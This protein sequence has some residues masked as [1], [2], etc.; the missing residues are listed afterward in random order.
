MSER[1]RVVLGLTVAAVFW[2]GAIGALAHWGV[3]SEGGGGPARYWLT[4]PREGE[5][6]VWVSIR[7][8]HARCRAEPST[9][10][11][12][13]IVIEDLCADI[14]EHRAHFHLHTGDGVLLRQY[15]ADSEG[16]ERVVA[17]IHY[18][19]LVVPVAAASNLVA[20]VREHQHGASEDSRNDE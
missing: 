2:A 17:P 12:R 5:A 11:E 3:F 9:I 10:A 13:L 14:N 16:G 1:S 4:T 20:L 8:D 6:V 7:G 15:A 19:A 18:H